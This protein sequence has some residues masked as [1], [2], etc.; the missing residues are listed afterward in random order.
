LGVEE[1]DNTK[2]IILEL[3]ARLTIGMLNIG[4]N[5]KVLEHSLVTV[6]KTSVPT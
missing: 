2:D 1:G 3:K 4:Q 5:L 6:N